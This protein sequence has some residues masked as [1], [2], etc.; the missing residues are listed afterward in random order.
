MCAQCKI[1]ECFVRH[2]FEVTDKTMA[3]TATH[4]DFSAHLQQSEKDLWSCQQA[5]FITVIVQLPCVEKSISH[6]N[7]KQLRQQILEKSLSPIE[8][9]NNHPPSTN[10]WTTYDG[11]TVLLNF[12]F[13]KLDCPETSPSRCAFNLSACNE[14]HNNKSKIEWHNLM[15]HVMSQ[16]TLLMR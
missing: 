4:I 13:N 2:P 14:T 8:L 16:C 3:K 5:S 15:N 1:L 12:K 6:L 10:G 11:F 7:I 9:H